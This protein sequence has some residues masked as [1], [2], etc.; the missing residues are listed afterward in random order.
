[1]PGCCASTSCFIPLMV[2]ILSI[3]LPI[4]GCGVAAVFGGM[5]LVFNGDKI[6]V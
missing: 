1:M 5:R 3:F 6:A 4:C 2:L